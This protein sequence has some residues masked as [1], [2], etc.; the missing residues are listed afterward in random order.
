MTSMDTG[1]C[2]IRLIKDICRKTLPLAVRQSYWIAKIKRHVYWYGLIY[3]AD[4]YDC[5]TDDP[6]IRS[7]RT[8]SDSIVKGFAPRSVID[9]GCGTGAL[10]KALRDRGCQVLGLEYSDAALR[11]CRKQQVPVLKFNLD[12]DTFS[13]PRTFD[14]VVSMEVAEHLPARTADRYVKLLSS[15]SSVIVFTAAP[16]GQGGRTGTD[17]INEQ[18]PSYW[19]TKFTHLGFRHDEALS[20]DWRE[21]WKAAGDVALC[22]YQNLMIFTKHSSGAHP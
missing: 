22:Y 12:K 19:I 17:H 8:I 5:S 6:A 1:T 18:P 3:D 7:V 2:A 11:L 20:A 16:P 13:D 10:L 4:Y 21:R 14:V 15:L 9:V